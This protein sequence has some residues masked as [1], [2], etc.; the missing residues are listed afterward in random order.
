M[1]SIT[2]R[3]I[4]NR[5]RN[6]ARPGNGIRRS[7][8]GSL[9]LLWVLTLSTTI[10]TLIIG[11]FP[12]VLNTVSTMAR[13]FQLEQ[14]ASLADAG[15]ERA[16]WEIRGNNKTNLNATTS[17]SGGWTTNAA[18]ACDDEV[19][20]GTD[21]LL[22]GVTVNSCRSLTPN[23]SVLNAGDNFGGAIGSYRVWVVN[24]NAL[25]SRIVSRGYVPNAITPRTVQTVMLDVIPPPDTLQ[26]GLF[27][28]TKLQMGAND[29]VF[30]DSYRSSQGAYNPLSP[31]SNG[32]VG[33]NG[34]DPTYDL[35]VFTSGV[36]LKG[37]VALPAGGTKQVPLTWTPSGGYQTTAH[38]QLPPVMIPSS[39]ASLPFTTT[40]GVGNSAIVTENGSGDFWIKGSY[41]CNQAIRARS[42]LVTGS[43]LMT[44]SCQL[45]VDATN[46]DGT[47]HTP[48][49]GGWA[50][51][52]TN[53]TG[54]LLK[55]GTGK[56]QIFMSNRGLDFDGGGVS[57]QSTVPEASRR[58]ENLQMYVTCSTPPC[59][60]PG[61]NN[62]A[63]HLPFYG[64]VYIDG[65]V[66]NIWR[67]SENGVGYDSQYYG[68]FVSTGLLSVDG[69]S[70]VY[71]HVHFDEDLIGLTLDGTGVKKF[72]IKQGSWFETASF[73]SCS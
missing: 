24:H 3:T 11:Y 18:T 68:A 12:F 62:M 73:P 55:T 10:L 41:T 23:P 4:R 21:G 32:N 58:P 67:A 5:L 25:T 59:N 69:L 64:V 37:A 35:S 50:A 16:L 63:Q 7:E 36:D 54:N 57:Y 33:T 61:P 40:L 17:P 26:Y 45:Y 14:A 38:I 48:A 56:T 52:D 8:R 70:G 60:I 34:L 31:L 47:L 15:V 44:D 29:Q 72:D 71:P 6:Q 53:G 27:S 42:I 49:Y 28:D 43:L 19:D 2:K 22:C 20:G 30:I 39:L 46:N 66:L 13:I 1:N 65:G 9:L 51:I